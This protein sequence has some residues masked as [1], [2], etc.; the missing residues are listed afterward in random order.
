LP[1]DGDL[2]M[3]EDTAISRAEIISL[4]EKVK[5]KSVTMFFDTCYSGQTRDEKS[6]VASLRPIRLRVGDQT[7]PDKFHIFSASTANQTSGSIV[8]A[9]HGVFSYYLMKGL[10]GKADKN[11]DNRITNGELVAFLK[12]NVTKESLAHNRQQEPT[13]SGDPDQ[14]LIKYR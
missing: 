9:K 14:V 13:L 10:E 7:V 2:M 8:Q 11:K 12:T 5:P 6:L 1:Y 3:L 4:V